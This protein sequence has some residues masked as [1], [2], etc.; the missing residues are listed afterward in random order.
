MA[1]GAHIIEDDYDSEY[2]YDVKPIPPMFQTGHGRVIYVGTLSK[3]L[4]PTLR[5]GYLVLPGHLVEVFTRCKQV[6]DR[7]RAAL[8]QEAL[9]DL[10]STGSYERHVR[11]MRRLNGQRRATLITALHDNF[12]DAVEIAGSSAGLHVVVWFRWLESAREAW[13]IEAAL[14]YGIGVYPVSQLYLRQKPHWAGLVMG[15]ASQSP[16][17]LTKGLK[18]LATALRDTEPDRAMDGSALCGSNGQA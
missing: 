4:S 16:D 8:E 10:F 1:D 14:R 12:G 2:R 13:L 6:A 11:R 3:T 5:L 9:A 17:A 7:H 15:Y 18:L